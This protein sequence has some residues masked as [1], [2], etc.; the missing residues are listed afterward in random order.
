MSAICKIFVMA[1][2]TSNRLPHQYAC[3]I[4]SLLGFYSF[5]S[6]QVKQGLAGK[7]K[8]YRKKRPS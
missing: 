6:L 3:L 2:I 7:L 4:L 5:I 1:Y 8:L